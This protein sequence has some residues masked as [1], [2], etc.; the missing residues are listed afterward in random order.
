MEIVKDTY[1]NEI[2]IINNEDGTTFSML[3]STYDEMLNAPTTSPHQPL[4]EG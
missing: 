4:V 2:V 1:D 3:K